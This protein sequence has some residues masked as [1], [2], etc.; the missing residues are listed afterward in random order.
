VFSAF[1]ITRPKFAFV[2]S[3]VLTI[4]G[5]IGLKAL[6]IEQFPNITPPVVQVTTSYPGA[7]AQV[8]VDTVATVIEREV[9]GVDNMIYMSS[10]S[11]NNGG[12]TL[13]VSFDIG[14]DPDINTVNV[15]NRVA[16]AL[17]SLPV[18]VTRE[19]VVT[20]KQ[21]T[22]M[23]M[24][25]NLVSPKGTYDRLFLSNYAAI[26]VEDP[27]KRTSGVGDVSQFGQLDYAMRIW[28]DTNRLVGFGL[29]A[30]DVANAIT[31]QNI[32]ASAGQIGAPPFDG[33]QQRQ[34]TLEAKGRLNTVEEFENIIIRANLNGSTVR[35]KD[36]ASTE[37]SSRYFSSL[38]LMDDAQPTAMVAIYQSP[39]SNA[40]GT[41]DAIYKEMDLLA[42]RFPEDLEYKI[43][44]D[45]TDYVRVSIKEVVVTLF[46]A[47]ALVA[48]VTFLFLGDWRATLI[49]LIAIPVSLIGTFAFLLA[50]GMTINTITLF[51]LILA[52]GLVVDDAIVV[53]EN[54]QRLIDD[55]DMEP[56]E[57]TRKAMLQI[58][59]PVVATT[60]VLLAVFVPTGF[61][62]GI[63]GVLYLQFAV[64]ISVAVLISSLNALTL[65]PALCSL[66]LRKRRGP[67]KGFIGW[68]FKVIDFCREKYGYLVSV[69]ARRIVLTII[70]IGLTIALGYKLGTTLPTGFVPSEDQGAFMADI[71][72]PAGASLNRT[73]E[74]MEDM[75]KIILDTPGVTNVLYVSGFSLLAGAGSNGG[76]AIGILEDWDER[77]NEEKSLKTI[78]TSINQRFAAIPGANAV[79][80]NVPPIP[81]LGT[82]GGFEME[83][84]DLAAR[85]PQELQSA[86]GG[87]LIA[88]NQDPVVSQVF[89]RYD[90]NSPQL[91]I[92]V[93]RDKTEALGVPI[94]D[95]FMTL[96]A[97]LGSLYVN[98][99]NLYGR[100]YRVMIQAEAADRSDI[101]DI[102]NL[103]VRSV[104][105]NM[106]PISSLIDIEPSV[107]PP[108]ITR[109]NLY[110]SASVSGSSGQGFSSG[111][112]IAAME[113]L[114]TETLPDGYAVAWTGTT[115][116][117]I[118]SAG[119]TA[120]I[121]VLA[122]LF[123]YLFLV[124][125]YESWSIPAPVILSVSVAIVGAMLGATAVGLPLNIYAQIGLVLLIGLASK[126]AILIVEFAKE[127]REDGHSI[128]DATVEASK[129][130]F[131]AVMMT[132][133]SFI[134][135]V[136]PLV[137]ATGAGAAGRVSLGV[138]VFTGMLAATV[139]GIIYIPILYYLFQ[140]MRERVKSIGKKS[141]DLPEVEEGK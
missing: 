135:G 7:N 96:Q 57:A 64:T 103:Y 90:A 36:V 120:S 39:G 92:D 113:K 127:L 109:Y 70:L 136:V 79:A 72:L 27:L 81:G 13:D 60:L 77:D 71:Q 14:T 98:D 80:F 10:T 40:L 38:A 20:Q 31:N 139:I 52:I 65:S 118:Q 50:F 41:A 91:F 131:R 35:V 29:T 137:F 67:P 106:I 2:I 134:L 110:S 128:F 112:A 62:P 140:T 82:T 56:P 46:Q 22:S 21:S 78:L 66:L 123:V 43:L 125:Q 16:Q 76:L 1:F 33:P 3:I 59:G 97:N 119:K 19:G 111:Q 74:V 49:P 84:Q 114:G 102:D 105:G 6:P 5:L 25:V 101:G 99:F 30:T 17:S 15:Q 107:G 34:Y 126:N 24:V 73:E 42:E 83:L 37:I 132:A 63:T 8:V 48:I 23:L 116:Q 55:E 93:N 61:L 51:A 124:A 68:F 87:L 53:V 129:L 86:L 88:A 12:Y 58:T 94:S 133:F 95:V 47:L 121:F 4:V 54:T 108:S 9:N 75:R 115:F 141:T 130:R 117:E 69:M 122:I 104:T 89:S 32:Q 11:D 100:V 138:I 28:L 18:E 45:T 44:Y 85:S 26:N